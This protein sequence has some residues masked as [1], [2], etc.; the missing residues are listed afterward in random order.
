MFNLVPRFF[1][2]IDDL[3]TT[4]YWHNIKAAFAGL[5]G[6]FLVTTVIQPV[7]NIC[8]S[9]S[10]NDHVYTMATLTDQ[11]SRIL[12]FKEAFQDDEQPQHL[13]DLCYAAL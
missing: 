2:V 12:F 7:A 10:V 11:D 9:S 3:R 6:R 1:I 5:T 4:A 13:D 8:R